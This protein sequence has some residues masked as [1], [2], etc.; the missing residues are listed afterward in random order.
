MPSVYPP[1]IE[2]GKPAQVTLY[3]RNLPGGSP[4]PAATIGGRPLEQ[5]TVTVTP[6][7]GEAAADYLVTASDL[8]DLVV[9]LWQAG[10]VAMSVNGERIVASTAFTDIGA[11]ILVN[12][13]YLQPP[14]DVS[15][16]G[17]PELYD[18]LTTSPSFVELVRNRVQGYGLELGFLPSDA[19]VVPAFA[20]AVTITQGRPL[21]SPSP[22]G[23]G[24]EPAVGQRP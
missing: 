8:R 21:P 3:G 7:P 24:D 19:V 17:P 4:D 16:I 2:P 15:V 10:A 1:M 11:S 18:R 20:G 6:P 22:G 12:S 5:L 13:A 9:E 14:Y 23:R